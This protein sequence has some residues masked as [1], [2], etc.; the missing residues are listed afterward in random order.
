MTACALYHFRRIPTHPHEHNFTLGGGGGGGGGSKL[1]SVNSKVKS[2]SHEVLTP[3]KEV[4][5]GEK[6]GPGVSKWRSSRILW[7]YSD[8]RS[9][10]KMDA[11][12]TRRLITAACVHHVKM[13]DKGMRSLE[14][15]ALLVRKVASLC[16]CLRDMGVHCN[17]L[18]E[19]FRAYNRQERPRKHGL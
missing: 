5:L 10:N 19:C 1:A 2:E 3:G 6:P 8:L 15:R 14:A 12:T 16:G 13:E 7:L 17:S 9:K 11:V 18:D 4:Q